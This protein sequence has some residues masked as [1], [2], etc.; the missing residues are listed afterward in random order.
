[1]VEEISAVKAC[2]NPVRSEDAASIGELSVGGAGVSDGGVS[3]G[4]GGGVSVGGGVAH[5]PLT[6]V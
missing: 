6:Q 5:E 4:G 1:M 2:M 3:I